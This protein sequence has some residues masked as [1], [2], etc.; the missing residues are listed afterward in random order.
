LINA[1]KE[2]QLLSRRLAAIRNRDFLNIVK[3]G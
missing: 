2:E 1:K 3:P